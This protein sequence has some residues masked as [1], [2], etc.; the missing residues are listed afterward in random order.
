MSLCRHAFLVLK[1]VKLVKVLTHANSANRGLNMIGG[2]IVVI[3]KK[4][5]A[6]MAL[7]YWRIYAKNALRI[8]KYARMGLPA[9]HVSM[10][11]NLMQILTSVH[12]LLVSSLIIKSVIRVLQTALNAPK[13]HAQNARQISYSNQVK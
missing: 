8:A 1:I 5:F 9:I 3:L 4:Y 13:K 7:T 12:A 11:V 2:C 10:P 6:Q